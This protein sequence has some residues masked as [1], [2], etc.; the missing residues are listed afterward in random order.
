MNVAAAPAPA[1]AAPAATSGSSSWSDER[2]FA[3]PAEK[4]SDP[5]RNFEAAKKAILDGYY[6][7]S[8]TEED[9][10]RAAVAGMLERADPTMRKWHKLLSPSDLADLKSDLQGEVVGV[11]VVIGF[12]AASGYIDVKG[13]IPG[14]PAERA[15]LARQGERVIRARCS[16]VERLSVGRIGNPSYL[17]GEEKGRVAGAVARPGSHRSGR[18][19]LRHPARQLTDSLLTAAPPRAAPAAAGP[20]A[21]D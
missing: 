11:G 15:G 13:T 17:A 3:V 19:Q 18:A 5:Q 20:G 8:L 14:S 10:Y 2:D 12:D 16:R 1:A 7:G 6:S 9:L 4:F 21:G